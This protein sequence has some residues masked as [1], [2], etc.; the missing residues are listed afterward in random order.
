ML[1]ISKIKIIIKEKKR[2]STKMNEEIEIKKANSYAKGHDDGYNIGYDDGYD[3][4]Y[5][6]GYKQ[7]QLDILKEL[8]DNI[9]ENESAF[10][11]IT[12]DEEDILAIAKEKN[13]KIE[14]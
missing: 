7:G 2:D 12:I 10:Y 4:G 8:Y 5:A 6:N 3:D 13:L 11:K 9:K 14:E 1:T